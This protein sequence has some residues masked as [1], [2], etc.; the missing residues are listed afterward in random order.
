MATVFLHVGQCGNQL[1]QVFWEE[2]SNSKWSDS[3]K[4][5]ARQ[6][7]SK[8]SSKLSTVSSRRTTSSSSS[9]S[10]LLAAA[11]SGSIPFSLVDGSLPCV[12]VD[13]EPKV[14]RRCLDRVNGSDILARRVP[15]ERSISGRTG[16]G[17]N[18]AFGYHGRK[19]GAS[20]CDQDLLT[21]VLDSVRKLVEKCDRF[22]GFVMFHS[23]AGG[24]GSGEGDEV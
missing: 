14:V 7:Y 16:R 23:I 13:T 18:W 17:N 3:L 2:V 10:S 22:C 15:S 4:N 6:R 20:G 24:T 5:D 19:G 21:R 12:L 1:G 8:P 9:P 11:S